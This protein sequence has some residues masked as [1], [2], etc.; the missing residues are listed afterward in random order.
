MTSQQNYHDWEEALNKHMHRVTLIDK[1]S[2]SPC[3]VKSVLDKAIV[4]AS[5]GSNACSQ[6]GFPPTKNNLMAVTAK[7]PYMIP[8]QTN[9]LPHKEWTQQ[10]F[11][12]GE[13][14]NFSSS[15]D[16]FILCLDVISL[17]CCY[18]HYYLW[19]YLCAIM[20]AYLIV[21][22]MNK[23][24]SQQKSVNWLV[25]NSFPNL[26]MYPSHLPKAARPTQ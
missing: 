8:F 3:L 12:P 26:N 4:V 15:K 13:V 20:I 23:L 17:S 24:T 22:L 19:T 1:V 18:Q 14:S 10:P 11:H 5:N 2:H 9:H 6:Q 7:C 21:P 25:T 16:T